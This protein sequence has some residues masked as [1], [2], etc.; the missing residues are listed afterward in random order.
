MACG[1]I[2]LA[3]GPKPFFAVAAAVVLGFGFS[4]P[5]ASIASTVLR[6]TPS[7]QHGS[8]I[9]LLSAF[10][11]LFVGLSSF[12][13]GAVAEKFGYPPIFYL[14]AGA[15]VISAIFGRFVFFPYTP[16]IGPPEPVEQL[17]TAV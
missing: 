11:D 7:P 14:A 12:G 6:R 8:I 5:W 16:P 3:S 4:F 1:L 9:S 13:A 2:W 17:E 10:Y 15:L